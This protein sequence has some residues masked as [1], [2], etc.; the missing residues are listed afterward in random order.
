MNFDE[1]V[2]KINPDTDYTT[3]QIVDLLPISKSTLQ[4]N[5]NRK[6]FKSKKIFGKHYVKG[7]DLIDYLIKN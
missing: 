4:S 7:K 5:I 1:I 6:A 3:Q 2:K